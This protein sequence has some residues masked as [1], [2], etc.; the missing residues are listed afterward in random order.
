MDAVM[1]RV[2]RY[3]FPRSPRRLYSLRPSAPRCRGQTI[4][5]AL[6]SVPRRP[7][8]AMERRAKIRRVSLRATLPAVGRAL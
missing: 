8:L 2:V 1:Q 4:G 6:R 7:E 3:H 5:V